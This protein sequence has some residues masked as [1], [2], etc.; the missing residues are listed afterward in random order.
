ME[1]TYKIIEQVCYHALLYL[2][3]YFAPIKESTIIILVLI[4][5]DLITGIWKAI[6][7]ERTI[8][9]VKSSKLR[10]TVSKTI[11][12]SLFIVAIFLLE[13]GVLD[14]S[15]GLTKVAIFSVGVI[16]VVSLCENLFA[17]S[18][19]SLYSSFSVVLKDKFKALINSLK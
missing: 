14:V 3:A 11:Q 18:G 17:I 12:Y 16:E 15:W 8:F 2:A 19:N 4:G 9:A 10:D 13:S 7:Q 1:N 6:S 5:F